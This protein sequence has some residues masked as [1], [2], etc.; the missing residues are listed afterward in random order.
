[1]KNCWTFEDILDIDQICNL[2]SAIGLENK[3]Q[4]RENDHF[5]NMYIYLIIDSFEVLFL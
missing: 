3:N 4:W 1:M 2:F 5:C